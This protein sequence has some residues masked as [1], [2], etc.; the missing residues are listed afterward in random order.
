MIKG[1]GKLLK[2]IT[3]LQ[4][5]CDNQSKIILNDFWRHRQLARL[6]NIVREKNRSSTPTVKLDPK[7][8]DQLLG[9]ITIMH[10][11]YNLYLRFLRRKV[12]VS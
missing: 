3:N 9:E 5:E 7:D 4:D 1:P 11:R 8:L 10:S 6:T 12:A 2:L